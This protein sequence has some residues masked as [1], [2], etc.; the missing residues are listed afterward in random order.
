MVVL[1]EVSCCKPVLVTSAFLVAII[2]S[3]CVSNNPDAEYIVLPAVPGLCSVLTTPLYSLEVSL[4]SISHVLQVGLPSTFGS[5]IA[6][7]PSTLP[8]AVVIKTLPATGV[9]AVL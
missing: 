4:N 2:V 8:V 9:E 6:N 1:K 7:V 3:C 5:G